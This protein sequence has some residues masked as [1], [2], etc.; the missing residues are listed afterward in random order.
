MRSKV[1]RV[2]NFIQT[3]AHQELQDD[4]YI[5]FLENLEYEIDRELEE[6]WPEEETEDE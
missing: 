2:M 3:I 6:G 5:E 1:N 4:Q